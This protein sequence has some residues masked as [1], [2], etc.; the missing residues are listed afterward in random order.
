MTTLGEVDAHLVLQVI[1]FKLITLLSRA[2]AA[3]WRDVEHSLPE[4]YERPPLH[5]QLEL[6]KVGQRPVEDALELF[7]SQMRHQRGLT[8]YCAILMREQTVLGKAPVE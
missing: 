6:R 2:I 3:D 1:L 8:D 5:W 7:L 4:F